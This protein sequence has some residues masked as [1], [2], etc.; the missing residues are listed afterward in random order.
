MN[1]FLLC[2]AD[3]K[4]LERFPHIGEFALQRINTLKL[5]EFYRESP[6]LLRIFYVIEGKF[7]WQVQSAN[8]V[9]YPGD[10]LLLLPGQTLSSQ[11]RF[12]N[13][14]MLCWMKIRVVNSSKKPAI[15]KWSGLSHADI[16][17]LWRILHVNQ[18]Q[19]VIKLKEVGGLLNTLYAELRGREVGYRTRVNAILADLFILFGRKMI[20]KNVPSH[21]FPQV[22]LKLDQAL[23][24]NLSKQWAVEEMAAMAGMGT[25]AFTEKVK[26]YSGFSPLNYLISIRI[27]EAIRLL[28]KGEI[29][30]TD[31]ALGVGF[32]SSQHFS[33]TFKKLTGYTPS[34]FRKK[35]LPK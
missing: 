25:T 18:H 19:L 33:T 27:S 11:E 22:F 31:I 29:S 35:N 28:K 4:E 16:Q 14:G 2:Q 12:L 8:H 32:Y 13:V 23:R 21:D 6:D 1:Q 3:S 7:E 5:D 24:Q 15:S 9:L 30:V 34:E 26:S 10:T 17:H 20:S